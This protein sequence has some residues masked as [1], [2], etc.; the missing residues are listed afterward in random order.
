MGEA[1][2]IYET[3]TQTVDEKNDDSTRCWWDFAEMLWLN[4][5]S[6][7]ARRLVL[8][9]SGQAAGGTIAVL[10]AKRHTEE[11]VKR[12]TSSPL[13]AVRLIK[14]RLLLELLSGTL[15]STIDLGKRYLDNVGRGTNMHEGVTMAL[16]VMIYHH[17]ITLRNHAPPGALRVLASEAIGIYPGNTVIM[18]VFLES[19]KGESIWGRVRDV[20]SATEGSVEQSLTRRLCEIWV[21]GWDVARWHGELEK[22]RNRLES[23]VS[24]ERCV[25][26]KFMTSEPKSIIC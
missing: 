9:Y 7:D 19:E 21:A 23:A 13:V 24:N 6:D 14:M 20:F 26:G 17:T 8:R 22:T 16:L 11:L 3:I 12:T 1:R 4:G 25:A 5:D 2:K 10:R 15:Q 18:G